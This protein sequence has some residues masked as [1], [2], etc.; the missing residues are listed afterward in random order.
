MT[1]TTE[2]ARRHAIET[3]RHDL[4]TVQAMEK[5]MEISIRWEPGSLEWQMAA[6]K[7][8]KRRYQRCI[9]NLE[10]LVVARMF[11]LTKMNMSHTG[12]HPFPCAI[13]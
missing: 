13:V 1:K 3:Q 12:I 9:D 7:V 2:T 10:C 4:A 5:K 8:V 6:E 11:E